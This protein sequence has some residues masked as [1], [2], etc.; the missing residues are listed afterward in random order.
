M[1]TTFWCRERGIVEKVRGRE[2]KGANGLLMKVVDDKVITAQSNEFT[3]GKAGRAYIIIVST[4]A[5]ASSTP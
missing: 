1:T 2:E 3:L 5:L 4:R